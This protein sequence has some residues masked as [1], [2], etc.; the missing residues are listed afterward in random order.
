MQNWHH[1]IANSHLVSV[2]VDPG[3]HRAQ[4]LDMSLLAETC[5]VILL[6]RTQHEE[7][8]RLSFEL[9]PSTCS[10]EFISAILFL[11]RKTKHRP[12]HEG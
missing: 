12:G 9:F 11:Y 1:T 2:I 6:F 5:Q 8:V 7:C 3:V 10:L 4:D